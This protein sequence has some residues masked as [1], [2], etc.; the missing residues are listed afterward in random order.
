MVYPRY[1]H[2][3][4]G[5]GIKGSENTLQD[6]HFPL[7]IKILINFSPSNKQVNSREFQV[8][9]TQKMKKIGS[10]NLKSLTVENEEKKQSILEIFSVT[11]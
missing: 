6:K 11:A 10:K 3:G 1:W 9:H 7:Y 5:W 8:D 4:S 2:Q